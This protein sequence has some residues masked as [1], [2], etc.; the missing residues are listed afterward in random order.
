MP[1]LLSREAILAV[2]DL[3]S[4]VVNVPE[5]GGDVKVQGLT[6]AQR[7]AFEGS[8]MLGKGKDRD[9]NLKN[10]RA[11][12]VA[13]SIVDEKGARLFTDADVNALGAKSAT[14][15][16]RVFE[17]AQRLSGLTGEDVEALEKNSEGAPSD[18]GLS[19]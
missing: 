10:L 4:E 16:N 5:W 2:P 6:G 7:D 15:L 14:A 19:G 3:Q 1:S 13:L 17:V 18:G 8:V 12:L 9:V 11:K